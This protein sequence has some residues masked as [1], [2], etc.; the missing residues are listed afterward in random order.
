MLLSISVILGFKKEISEK[1]FGFWGNIHIV[2][3]RISRTFELTPVLKNP[4]LLDSIQS[5]GQ[6]KYRSSLDK[7]EKKTKGGVKSV[8][9]FITFPAIMQNADQLEGI[10]LKGIDYQYN[11][12][13][14]SRYLKEG[15][16]PAVSSDSITREI[17]ISEQTAKRLRTGIGDRLIINFVKERNSVKRAF[18]ITGI[19]KTGLEIYDKK[20]AFIDMRILQDILDW[21]SEQVGGFEVFTD[22]IKDAEPIADYIYSEVLPPHLYAETIQEK[23]RSE[24]EWLQL[25]DINEALILILMILVAIINMSTAI[26]ILILERSRMIGILKALGMNNWNIRKIFIYNAVWIIGL[27]LVGGN[28]L[29]LGVA[30]LQ[31]ATGFI[32]LDETNYYLSEAPISF[33]WLAILYVNGGTIL[34]TALVMLIPSVLVTKIL[35]TKIL[36]FE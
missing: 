36:R 2:D 11:W 34:V 19:Y 29:G 27:A 13:Q 15:T 6:L 31:K 10:I 28:I 26:L 21:S 7:P 23:F 30:Y 35:P 25:Q 18:R 4:A 22:Y 1:I 8:H 20:F 24:F 16:F 14:F 32:K 3:T 12:T 5:I 9:P 33:D 17:L